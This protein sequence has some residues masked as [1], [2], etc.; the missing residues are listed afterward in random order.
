[1]NNHTTENDCIKHVPTEELSSSVVNLMK[2]FI[3]KEL[4]NFPIPSVSQWLNGTLEDIGRGKITLKFTIRPEMTNPSGF[5][6][7]GI[8]C[9]MLDD[10]MG[11]I[12]ATLGYDVALLSTNLSMDY[13]GTAKKN[14]T[15]YCSAW[16]VREGT[17]MI[18]TV[19]ELRDRNNEL[20]SKAQSNL[21]ISNQHAEYVT[22]IK[23]MMKG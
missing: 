6:H 10:A 19:G 5:F 3:G 4:K 15:V 21:I 20:I 11:T 8:Q 1:V 17:S 16:V 13:L 18:H 2:L 22:M 23:K 7:G 12:A 14:D 9:A